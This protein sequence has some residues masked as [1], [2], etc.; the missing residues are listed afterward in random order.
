MAMIKYP[1]K[2]PKLKGEN[3]TKFRKNNIK[4]TE[5]NF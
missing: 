2:L 3:L 5:T 4:K 1:K